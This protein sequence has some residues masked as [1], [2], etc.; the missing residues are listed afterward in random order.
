MLPPFFAIYRTEIFKEVR[1]TMNVLSG[2]EPRNKHLSRGGV[3]ES[4]R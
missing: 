2:G 4:R 3:R 1:E